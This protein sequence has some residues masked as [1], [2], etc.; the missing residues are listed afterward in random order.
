MKSFEGERLA[1]TSGKGWLCFVDIIWIFFV[2]LR[3]F[4]A[5]YFP[6]TTSP[7]IL[8]LIVDMC[9]WNA[10]F[11]YAPTLIIQDGNSWL[12]NQQHRSHFVAQVKNRVLVKETSPPPKR[13]GPCST[14]EV[15]PGKR[16]TWEADIFPKPSR[17]VDK[18]INSTQK[19][20]NCSFWCSFRQGIHRLHAAKLQ[21]EEISPKTSRSTSF[22]GASLPGCTCSYLFNPV[23]P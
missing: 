11:R 1:M 7:F 20:F 21:E 2:L 17:E 12:H 3:P 5:S 15:I 14:V 6:A 4:R 18:L 13:Q 23:N 9:S 16:Y 19:C 22:R 8:L 10:L